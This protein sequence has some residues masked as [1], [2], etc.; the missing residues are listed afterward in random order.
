MSFGRSGLV[1]L[2]RAAL[3]RAGGYRDVPW[4][5]DFDLWHRLVRSGARLAKLPDRLLW[6][7]DH[8]ARVTRTRP[9]GSQA[10]LLAA[11]V[12]HLLAGPL[13]QARR[14]VV[15]GAGKVGKRLVRALLAAG[16][17]VVAIVDLHPRKLGKVIHGAQCVPPETLPTLA[18]LPLLAAVGKPGGREDIRARCRTL[19]LPPPLAVA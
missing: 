10:A 16:V 7:R 13:A 11:R 6:V 5:E 8:P 14:V 15:W 17:E 4:P 19:G 18:G 1:V 2:R 12:H 9:E 3:D